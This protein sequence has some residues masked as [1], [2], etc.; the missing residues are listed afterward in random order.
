MYSDLTKATYTFVLQ[1][2]N[3][4]NGK[5]ISVP[6]IENERQTERLGYVYK[7]STFYVFFQLMLPLLGVYKLA[8]FF[9]YLLF[10]ILCMTTF[11]LYGIKFDNM[12]LFVYSYIYMKHTYTYY[13]SLF[14]L[15]Q[16]INDCI[17]LSYLKTFF[18][19]N[20]LLNI[21]CLV[22]NFYKFFQFYFYCKEA[23]R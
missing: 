8:I 22:S 14:I 18:L 15:S 13:L 19:S 17:F 9:S 4:Y 11:K 23:K 3:V 5:K 10:K 16:A 21:C 12:S 1:S 2:T 6:Q 7:Y 20:F